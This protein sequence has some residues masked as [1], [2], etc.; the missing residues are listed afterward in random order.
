MK[1]IIIINFVF[2]IIFIS[3]TQNEAQVSI[4]E[5]FPNISFN[6]PVDIQNAGDG[7]DR[8]FVLSQDG[9]IHVFQNDE[10]VNSKKTFLDIR[11]KVLSGG[12][13]GLLGLA[14][15]PNYKNNGYFYVDY[16]V[17]NPRRTIISRYSVSGDPDA[18]D[19]NSEQ[20]LMEI[21]QPYA[22]HNGG[23][24]S[25]GLDGYL[26]I[27]LGD[28]GSG[29]DPLNNAQSL[30]SPLGKLLR[31]DIN[32]TEGGKN[33][34]IPEGNPFKGNTN[35]LVEEI[36]AWG[37]RNVWRFSFDNQGRIWGADVGQ[38]EWEE[39]NIIEAGKNYGWR[40]TE[41]FHCYNPASGCDKTNLTDPVWEYGHN[42]S[43][44][45]SITGGFV[46]EGS[47]AAELLGKYIYGD[48]VS[49]NLW[50]LQINNGTAENSLL[51]STRYNIS[52]FGVDENNELYFADYGGK[53]YKFKG[54]ETSSVGESI[55]N[56]FKLNQNYPNP[57]NPLT[58]ISFTVPYPDNYIYNKETANTDL[59]DLT[60]YDSLGNKIADLINDRDLSGYHE[61]QF[62]ASNLA[63]GVYFYSL[64]SGKI[65]QTKKMMLIK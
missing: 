52:T 40:I 51:F 20:I 13:Q 35:E 57:F 31:I 45:Y 30:K 3:C 17:S 32:S 42:Q 46:Y 36:Y 4:V 44:G 27:S 5:A 63:S 24:I 15:H 39:I 19:K 59:V 49:G 7:S 6:Q 48:Y 62:N 53:I 18:A 60:I 58:T 64:T 56:D 16:T 23:Q 8:L 25:F 28:G 43:G 34:S 12:E 41:G 38:N 65:K 37:L 61:F 11:D 54:T 2:S 47:G 22:N 26:Y 29:G 9:V 21:E 10:N 33:Y 55:K 1:R 50:G 14:F